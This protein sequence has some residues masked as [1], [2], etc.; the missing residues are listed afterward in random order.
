MT[1]ESLFNKENV[2]IVSILANK[3][4]QIMESRILN[5]KINFRLGWELNFLGSTNKEQQQ[6]QNKKR[7]RINKII[8]N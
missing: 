5:C 1:E 6:L 8:K 4:K 7:N 2:S 3:K